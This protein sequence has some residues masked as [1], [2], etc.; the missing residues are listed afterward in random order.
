MTQNFGTK[1]YLPVVIALIIAIGSILSAVFSGALVE[2]LTTEGSPVEI[3]SA[4]LWVFAAVTMFWLAP[5]QALGSYWHVTILF[6]FF[7]A[8]ELDYDKK[9]LSEGIF[10]AR[11]YSGDSPLIEK[12]VGLVVVILV[13]IIATRLI[14]RN[15]RDVLSGVRHGVG[16]VWMAFGAFGLAVISKMFDG[17]GRKLQGIG[18]SISP[19]LELKL[20]MAEETMELAFA[21][22]AIAA[23]CLFHARLAHDNNG[24]K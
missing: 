19:E 13:L 18:V 23:V 20:V 7:A 22:A 5:K 8:R 1:Y 2:S 3:A 21:V 12:I 9:F 10:K 4:A 11:Q 14:R 16:W 24:T 15:W 17:A 6:L